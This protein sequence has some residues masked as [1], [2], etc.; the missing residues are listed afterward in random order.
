MKEIECINIDGK[1]VFIFESHHYAIAPWASVKR[2][3]VNEDVCLFTFDSHTDI[4]DPF[5]AYVH[6]HSPYRQFLKLDESLRTKL[7]KSIDYNID[8]T[9]YE[10]IKKLKYDEHIKTAIACGI[11]KS[12]F[13]ISQS[14]KEYPLSVEENERLKKWKDIE[15]IQQQMNGTYKITPPEKRHYPPSDIYM[16]EFLM[17]TFN[18]RENDEGFHLEDDFLSTHF[19]VMARMNK[20]IRKDGTITAPYILDI[21]LD[22]FTT[23]NSILPKNINVFSKLVKNAEIITIA[24]ESDCVDL[25]SQGN[26][27]SEY[28]LEKLLLLLKNII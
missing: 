16:T 17:D 20:L 21:D 19:E 5:S 12:A 7:I 11:L 2:A 28:L 8:S 3:H 6:E 13:I 9:L 18:N 22:Y 10:A 4:I 25:C 24:K 15:S 23:K 26:V 27:T 1:K 14:G